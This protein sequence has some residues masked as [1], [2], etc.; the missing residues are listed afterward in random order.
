MV[1]NKYSIF[2]SIAVA[3]CMVLS[4]TGVVFAKDI[5][6]FVS[7]FFGGSASDGVQTA[8]DNGY[9]KEVE[10]KYVESEGIEFAV[11]SFLIDDYNLDINFKM[12]L[13][14]KYDSKINTFPEEVFV[15]EF[16]HTL[17]KNAEDYG[18]DRPELH[19]YE[20]YGYQNQKLVGLKQWYQDYLNKQIKSKSSEYI[21]LPE[22]VFNAKPSKTSDFNFSRQ[23]DDF[24]EPQNIFEELNGAFKKIVNLFKIKK[25]KTQQVSF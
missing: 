13:S 23:L 21:G 7:N 4:I 19:D 5:G 10:P 16:L 18:Y 12:K 9:L 25:I 17:E 8:V 15:H 14:N 20:K 2:K 1:K 24:R 6:N 11:D 3:C 22:Q